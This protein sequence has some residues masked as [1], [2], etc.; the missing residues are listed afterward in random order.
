LRGGTNGLHGTL[1]EYLRNTS[2]NAT[3]FFKPAGGTKPVLIQNQFGG[4]IGGPIKRDKLFYFADY[5]GFRRIRKQLQFATLPTLAQRTGNLG[6]PVMDPITGEVFA[7][8]IIPQ[9]R[10]TSFA[11]RVMAD[12]PAPTNAGAN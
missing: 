10:I 5:E 3:G 1:Y 2:L 12:L 8:G 9:D 4:S 6:N 11:R 7:N